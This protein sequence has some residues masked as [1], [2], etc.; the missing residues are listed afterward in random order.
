MHDFG[1]GIARKNQM[2]PSVIDSLASHAI[3]SSSQLF[4]LFRQ[5]KTY[6]AVELTSV[7]EVLSLNN[8]PINPVPNTPAFMLGLT[9]L[10]GDI[11]AVADLGMLIGTEGQVDW[12]SLDSRLLIVEAPH[13]EDSNATKIRMGLA[14]S[15]VEGVIS[16]KPDR[17]VSAMDVN[18][19]IAPFLRGL[20]HYETRLLMILDVEAISMSD[21]W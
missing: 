7:R 2:N 16:L 14:V 9:N 21:R 17:I 19:E 13:P 11:L 15:Q 3:H 1:E 8:Q 12:H 18:E 4:L 5:Q 10:R 6:Y 20:C